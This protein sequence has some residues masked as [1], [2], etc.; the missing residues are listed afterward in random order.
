MPDLDL[1]NEYLPAAYHWIEEGSY[2]DFRRNILESDLP[3]SNDRIGKPK[4][5]AMM[6]RSLQE[7]HD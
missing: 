6:W 3:P 2:E 1:V 7:D 5:R 4:N